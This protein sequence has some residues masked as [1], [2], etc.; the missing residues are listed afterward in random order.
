MLKLRGFS[1]AIGL[2]ASSAAAQTSD[3]MQRCLS[4]DPARSAIRS[5]FVEQGRALI[6]TSQERPET[7]A[8]AVDAACGAPKAA[9]VRQLTQCMRV[10]QALNVVEKLASGLRGAIIAAVVQERAGLR[11]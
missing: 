7:I 6:D 3:Q 5:C 2:C 9:M 4:L 10:D 1:L 8:T 11:R